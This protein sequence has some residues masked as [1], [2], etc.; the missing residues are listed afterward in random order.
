MTPSILD[1]GNALAKAEAQKSTTIAVEGSKDEGATVSLTT[2]HEGKKVSWAVTAWV[3]RMF[4]RGG[5]S[6]GLRGEVKF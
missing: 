3:K 5:T 4:G 2:A 6:G 1:S